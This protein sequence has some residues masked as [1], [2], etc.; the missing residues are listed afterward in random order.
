MRPRYVIGFCS[1]ALLTSVVM[2]AAP[3]IP[4]T[5]ILTALGLWL[6]HGTGENNG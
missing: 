6:V 5:I 1:G 3:L 4:I 2:Q